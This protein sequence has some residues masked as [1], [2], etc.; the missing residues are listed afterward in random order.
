M[1]QPRS[2]PPCRRAEVVERRVLAVLAV[3]VAA[4][5][6]AARVAAAARSELAV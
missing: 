3:R 2:T 1:R 5:A 4:A 6:R